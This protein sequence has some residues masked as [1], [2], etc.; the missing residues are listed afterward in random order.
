[1][2]AASWNFSPSTTT[3]VGANGLNTTSGGLNADVGIGAR[4]ELPIGPIRIDWGYPVKS[5]DW[6]NSS[7]QFNFNVGY[8]F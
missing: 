2:N 7:G 6:N 1:V 5:D 8:T 3:S 4:I